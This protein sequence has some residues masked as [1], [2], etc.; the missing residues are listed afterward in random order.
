MKRPAILLYGILCYLAFFLTFSYLIGFV[1]DWLVPRSVDRAPVAESLGD[2]LVNAGLIALFGVQH[3][4]MAR[5]AFKARW[6]R[7]VPA[8]AERSTFVLAT[9][10][11]LVLMFWQW[12][13]VPTVVWSFE[14]PVA[15]AALYALCG[16]GFAT[17]FVSSLLI[18][19]FELFG[20]RQSWDGFRGRPTQA[21]KFVER[22]LY[23]WV[24]HPLM[25]GILIAFWATPHMTLGHLMF[26]VL[27]SA[28][29]LIGTTMEE[30]DLMRAHRDSYAAYRARTAMLFPAPRRSPAPVSVPRDA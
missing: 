30:R 26:A 11:V 21:P 17:V 9:C 2:W 7:I 27:F 24:R 22:G 8:A 1:V 23:R 18:D 12:R 14:H 10:A 29:V 15:V 4:I 13:A 16:V 20:L 6:T 25:L 28:Y 3:A 19:H 5:P